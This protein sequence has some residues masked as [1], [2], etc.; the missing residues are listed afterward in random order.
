MKIF[1][2][3]NCDPTDLDAGDFDEHPEDFSTFEIDS[4]RAL[5][6][7]TSKRGSGPERDTCDQAVDHDALSKSQVETLRRL[8]TEFAREIAEFKASRRPMRE[9]INDGT[10]AAI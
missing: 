2:V 7:I 9:A 4:I 1:A 5:Q 10:P 3:Y 8:E 6:S